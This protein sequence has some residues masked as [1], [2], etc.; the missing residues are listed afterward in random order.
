[1]GMSYDIT[2]PGDP[3]IVIDRTDISMEA[4]QDNAT[5]TKRNGSFM[6]TKKVNTHSKTENGPRKQKLNENGTLTLT[7][8]P[9]R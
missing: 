9:A 6:I 4:N 2:C 3:S 7:I 1:M 8:S 5:L